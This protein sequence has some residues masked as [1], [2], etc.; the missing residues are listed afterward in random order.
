LHPEGVVSI[1]VRDTGCGM[2]KAVL[3]RIF[4]PFFTTHLPGEG[5]GLGL[6]VVHGIVQSHHGLVDVQSSPGQGTV[7]T[8][9]CPVTSTRPAAA[10]AGTTAQGRGST[11]RVDARRVLYI[12][13]EEAL[14][15]LV[16]RLLERRGYRV[17]A[18]TDAE[19]ALAA[20]RAAPGDF[21]L[22]LTDYN[23]PMT[24]GLD[25]AREA[26]AIRED[27]PVVITT[28]YV[29]DTLRAQATALGVRD[30]IF[31]ADTVDAFCDALQRVV[32]SISQGKKVN[33]N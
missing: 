16:P 14:V 15:S 25:V 24:S 28:G 5:T 8:L 33:G 12:D 7:F 23:M 26:R 6:S 32:E 4:D 20:L 19:L 30:V 2:D 13:D 27:V 17:T 3:S 22:V 9:Y 10:P 11:D 21:D 18:Y 31:K 29:D 1:A